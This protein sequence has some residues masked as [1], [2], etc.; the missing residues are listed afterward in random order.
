MF[1]ISIALYCLSWQRLLRL[2]MHSVSIVNVCHYCTIVFAA[3][4][5]LV[6]TYQG[7]ER[8]G[9]HDNHRVPEPQNH[10]TLLSLIGHPPTSSKLS[11]ALKIFVIKR[12]MSHLLLLLQKS[13]AGVTLNESHWLENTSLHS[14]VVRPI[15]QMY[16]C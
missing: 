10:I 3:V 1:I 15:V 13:T 16:P 5:S 6:A 11:N 12:C 14:Q 7:A 4:A 8:R 2:C 9:I